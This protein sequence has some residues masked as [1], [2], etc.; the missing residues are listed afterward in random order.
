MTALAGDAWR[1]WI[2]DGEPVASPGRT[3]TRVSP[4]LTRTYLIIERGCEGA[5]GAAVQ[6]ARSAVQPARTS[7]EQRGNAAPQTPSL[8]VAYRTAG[9]IVA[10]RCVE[11]ATR[12]P[13]ASP[14]AVLTAT[15]P[16]FDYEIGS[17]VAATE[18]SGLPAE[19][20]R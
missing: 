8:R 1:A 11:T 20:A 2:A 15:H 12:P 16:V 10:R 18:V 3:V 17:R 7:D 19:R 4:S 5:C 14:P 9:A 13:R 6:G